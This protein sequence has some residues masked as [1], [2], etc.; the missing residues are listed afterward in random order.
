MSDATT[1]YLGL[2][3]HKETVTMAVADASGAPTL[4]GTVRNRPDQIR[5]VVK[6]LS[7]DG[8]LVSAYEAGPTGYELHRQ[9]VGLGVES[10]VVAPTLTPVRPGDRVK[11]DN[12][13]AISLARLLRSGDLTPVWVPDPEHEA[14]RDLVR[15]REDAKVDLLRARQRLNKF[16]LRHAVSSPGRFTSWSRTHHEWLNKVQFKLPA[17]RLAFEDYL[18]A[19]RAGEDRLRRLESAL[20]E[21]AQQSPLLPVIAALQVLRGFAF[22]SAVTIV[23]EAGDFSRFSSARQFMAYTG[24]VPSEHSSGRTQSR[25]HITRSGNAHLRH[26]LVQ[27][28]HNARYRPN[29]T[30]LRKRLLDVPPDLVQIAHTAQQRLYTR[31]WHLQRRIGTAKAVTAVARELAG[32][33]WAVSRRAYPA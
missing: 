15:A 22:I 33:V 1:R 3:V 18:G 12:R 30:E 31:Y 27:A 24:L 28:A 21:C 5:Q 23:A 8:H 19:V 14:L 9:L 26:V 2:D 11:T 25:G 29:T 32:F 13:D 6:R 20:A 16:L 4:V 10:Y 17:Q 7:H